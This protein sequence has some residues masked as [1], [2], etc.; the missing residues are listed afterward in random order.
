MP[1]VIK[2]VVP[3]LT[4]GLIG[5]VAMFGLVYS[6][7]RPPATNPASTPVLTYGN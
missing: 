5:F 6:Q 7:T 3:V 4:G 2:M 1:F